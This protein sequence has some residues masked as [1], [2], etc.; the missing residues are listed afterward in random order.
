MGEV[1]AACGSRRETSEKTAVTGGERGDR[2]RGRHPVAG[3][4]ERGGVGDGVTAGGR[5]RRGRKRGKVNAGGSN[6]S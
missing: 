6:G 4:A 2:W 3:A 5:E 1:F